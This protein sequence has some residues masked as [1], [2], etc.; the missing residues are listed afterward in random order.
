MNN[1]HHGL[2][3]LTMPKGAQKSI[4]SLIEIWGTVCLTLR[5]SGIIAIPILLRNERCR[6]SIFS[7]NYALDSCGIHCI[8]TKILYIV[9]LL[10]FDVLRRYSARF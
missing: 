7:T 4:A 1:E 3:I 8:E 2:W 9:E 10:L 6:S 5:H